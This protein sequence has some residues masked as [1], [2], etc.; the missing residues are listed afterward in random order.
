M[1]SRLKFILPGALFLLLSS[2]VIAQVHS[3]TE[4]IEIR[5]QVRYSQG[6]SPVEN[7]IVRL[8][9]VSGGAV[10]EDRTDRLG[11]FRFAGLSP[12]QYFLFVHLQGYQEVRRE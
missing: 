10:T 9:S 11:K 3:I 12:R 6:G 8:E 1:P 7:V 2:S 4:P 5:G